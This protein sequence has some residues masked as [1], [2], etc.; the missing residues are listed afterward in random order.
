V[1]RPLVG[2][3]DEL[4][5]ELAR[6]VGG[7]IAEKRDWLTRALHVETAASP[8]PRRGPLASRADRRLEGSFQSSSLAKNEVE[9]PGRS[10]RISTFDR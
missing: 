1:V 4:V 6:V 9:L 10:R 2:D 3:A 7:T 8:R 5:E